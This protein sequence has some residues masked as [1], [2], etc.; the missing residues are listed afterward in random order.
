MSEA[1]LPGRQI[2]AAARWLRHAQRIL[3]FTGAGISTESGIPDYRGPQG[4][5]RIERDLDMAAAAARRADACLV[6]GSTSSV[7]PAPASRWRRCGR[8]PGS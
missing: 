2:E 7:W 1:A 3:V 4:L 6:V 5:W 8:E